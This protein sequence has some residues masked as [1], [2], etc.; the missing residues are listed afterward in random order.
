MRTLTRRLAAPVLASSLALTGLAA[1]TAFASP[2]PAMKNDPRLV[3]LTGTKNTRTFATYRTVDGASIT[4][5]VLRSDNLASLTDRDR[6]KLA[7]RGIATIIDLR[8]LPERALQPD[9]RPARSRGYDVDIFG[10]SLAQNA[11]LDSAY[12]FFVTDAGAR[13][14]FARALRLV[15]TTLGHNRAALFHCTSGKDRTGWTAAL[16]LTIAGVDRATVERDYL[17]SNKFRQ[18]T[19]NSG[20]E[21]V[22]IGWLR[23]SITTATSRYG[24]IEGY[25]HRGLGLSDGEIATLRNRLRAG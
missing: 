13:A 6:A 11:D 24:S 4:P 5:R 2:A 25:V 1:P 23:E 21:G 22:R 3:P 17:A 10:A 18:T 12:R 8:T 7:A 16:L 19:P 9:R 14:G 15:S 20:I